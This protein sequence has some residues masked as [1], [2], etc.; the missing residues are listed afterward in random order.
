MQFNTKTIIITIIIYGIVLTLFNLMLAIGKIREK[1]NKK[2]LG[3][4]DVITGMAG[5][6]VWNQ[7]FRDSSYINKTLF[8]II[9]GWFFIIMI[10]GCANFA[11][12]MMSSEP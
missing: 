12:S 8:W 2:Y 1:I 11:L 6:T 5:M 9:A 3:A 7:F 4:I 10:V